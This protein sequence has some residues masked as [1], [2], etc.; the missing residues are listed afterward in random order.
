MKTSKKGKGANEQL[1]NLGVTITTSKSSEMNFKDDIFV[2]ETGE[3]LETTIK[4][5][6]GFSGTKATNICVN[7]RTPSV[8]ILN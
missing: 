6:L 4:L 2:S 3:V 5:S 8:I 7:L 1:L